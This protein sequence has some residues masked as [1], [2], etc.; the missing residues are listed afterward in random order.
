MGEE[1]RKK[2][3][4]QQSIHEA[5]KIIIGENFSKEDQKEYNKKS[6]DST[7]TTRDIYS[8]LALATSFLF[9]SAC[10]S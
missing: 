9:P 10:F 6:R 2:I 3:E 7:F 4:Y 8:L 5:K 1:R